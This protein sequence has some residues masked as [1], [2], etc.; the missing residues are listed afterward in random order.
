MADSNVRCF[1]DCT[2][3]I[4]SGINTGIQRTVW[5]IINRHALISKIFDIKVIPVVSFNGKFYRYFPDRDRK[6]FVRSL[7]KLFGTTR[8]FLDTIFYGKKVNIDA[9]L[10]IS[11]SESSRTNA[12]D[13]FEAKST[14]GPECN[15]AHLGIIEFCR[16]ILPFFFRCAFYLDNAFDGFNEADIDSDD[17]IFY[18]DAFWHRCTYLTFT[19]YD[20]A[21]ILLL[22]DIIPISMP[23]VCDVVYTNLFRRNLAGVLSNVDGIISISSSELASIKAYFASIG[24]EPIPLLDYNY[25][26]ADF[27]VDQPV[28]ECVNPDIVKVFSDQQTF[29][30]VGTLEPRK[31]HAF[32]IDAFDQFWCQGGEA[33]LCIIGKV[34]LHCLGL[35]ERI[36]RHEYWGRRL[37]CLQD[38]NDAEL[39]YSYENCSGVIFASLA[40]GFGLPMVEAMWFGRQVLASD[41]AV[42]REIGGNYPRY[43]LPDDVH[44]LVEGLQACLENPSD[45]RQ[46]R[47]WLT[48]D[49][50]VQNLFDK[51]L[52]MAA[53]AKQM[54]GLA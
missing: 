45:C 25:W 53:A 35:K 40:E 21:K 48:W 11:I 12:D 22:H 1:V 3:T 19:R 49:E 14:Y 8:D 47:Q 16:K 7:S 20:A 39:A 13:G 24:L 54:K 28:P 5:N 41:I 17:L 37:F 50:S 15:N 29:L 30:M 44:G 52:H 4:C 43:F 32:V 26:G 34:S 33:S 23:Q 31:N 46:P 51:V 9:L 10:K 6:V 2:E 38:V 27:I 36:D 42:F 18:P